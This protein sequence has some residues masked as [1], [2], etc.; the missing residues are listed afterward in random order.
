MTPSPPQ[1]LPD[2][3]RRLGRGLEALLGA[4]TV[5]LSTADAPGGA[6]ATGATDTRRILIEQIR[7]NPFQPR[8]EFAPEALAELSASLK[9][10]GLLQPITIRP[11]QLSHEGRARLGAASYELIAGERRLR[12][13]MHLGWTD[14]PAIVRDLDD[15]AALTLALVENLQRADLN[16]IEE[17]EGYTQ[18]LSEFAL[19]QQQI[20][21]VVGKN[22][23]T[24]AN[25]LR[26]L[27]LP[28][29][30]RALVRNGQLTTGHARALLALKGERAM[31]AQ[32]QRIVRDSLTVRDAE[33]LSPKVKTLKRHKKATKAIAWHNSTAKQIEDRLRKYLQTDVQLALTGRDRGELAIHFYSND[34][35]ERILERIL[36]GPGAPHEAL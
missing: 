28:P 8:Q 10:N 27:N 33:A 20:A 23:S 17:A 34:D 16:A 25:T 6:A 18:L 4:P 12:A 7:P 32:A 30:V 36:G 9:A 11:A 2:S 22:R 24:V 5:P 19:T 1:P 31:I 21:D 26:L 35:L 29:S 14:I 13:A 15:R 3:H